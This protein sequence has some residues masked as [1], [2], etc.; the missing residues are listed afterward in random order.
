MGRLTTHVLDTAAGKPA[1]GLTIRLY[2]LKDGAQ[3]ELLKQVLQMPMGVWM[4]HC[5]KVRRSRPDSTG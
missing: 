4:R 1:S 2:A 3:P 5:W